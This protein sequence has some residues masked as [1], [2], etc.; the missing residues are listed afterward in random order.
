VGE[1]TDAVLF[2]IAEGELVN[3]G[4]PYGAPRFVNPWNKPGYK[5]RAAAV[6]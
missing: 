3:I 1:K 5:P 2:M 4:Y 6:K